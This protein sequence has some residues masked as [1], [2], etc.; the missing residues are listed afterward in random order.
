M[1]IVQYE[2]S[3]IISTVSIWQRRTFQSC[4]PRNA[5]SEI[6]VC[7]TTAY[8]TQACEAALGRRHRQTAPEFHGPRFRRLAG[9]LQVRVVFH[10]V[11]V[12]VFTVDGRRYR[13]SRPDNWVELTQLVLGPAE[14]VVVLVSGDRDT[15]L[16]HATK[17]T[18]IRSTAPLDVYSTYWS[19][20][21][22]RIRYV[23]LLILS[24]AMEVCI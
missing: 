21:E 6:D 14:E 5:S 18:R 4:K 13:H 16:R 1:R 15:Y 11:A 20:G 10:G 3:Y 17:A 22:I 23:N 19:C 7:S 2:R 24:P 12:T 8:L 9:E